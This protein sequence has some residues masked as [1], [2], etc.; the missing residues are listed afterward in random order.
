MKFRLKD[1]NR[2]AYID[3]ITNGLFSKALSVFMDDDSEE[4]SVFM[5]DD[6]EMAFRLGDKE[7]LKINR[8]DVE[9]IDKYSPNFWNAYP[10]TTPP[11]GVLMRV[12]CE[13]N[14][15]SCLVYRD[16]KWQYE[17]GE[18]FSGYEWRFKVRRYRPW[19]IRSQSCGT[20][21]LRAA[22]FCLLT[23]VIFD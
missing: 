18:P 20:C 3:N 21:R 4:L 8:N 17:S 10:E 14:L 5:D 19:N 1:R 22:F 15:R 2:H 12:E 6:C 13:N 23:F 9:S 11:E 7:L 16:S